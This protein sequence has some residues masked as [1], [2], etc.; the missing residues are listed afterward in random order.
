[1]AQN[2]IENQIKDKLNA[3]EIRPSAQSWDRL[4]AMLTV[5]EEKKPSRFPFWLLSIAASFLVL[6]SVGL[7][8]FSQERTSSIPNNEVIVE[9]EIQKSTIIS[10]PK[11]AEGNQVVMT[12]KN[13]SKIN[14]Q[15]STIKNQGVSVSNQKNNQNPIINRKKEIEFLGNGDVALKDLPQIILTEPIIIQAKKQIFSKKAT[16]IDVDALLA[17]AENSTKNSKS[18][19]IS[20]D[21]TTLLSYADSEV[22]TTFRE[23]VIHKISKN[24][25]E[26]K[27][28]LATRNQE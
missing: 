2:N 11:I 28:A 1:M 17:S 27:S 16:Y 24:Y 18:V 6:L 13:N 26:V 8:F 23:K 25:Q 19:K 12:I 21:A 4:D 22:E 9:A 5:S 7:F 14:I 15:Q 3:R 10:E 20:V